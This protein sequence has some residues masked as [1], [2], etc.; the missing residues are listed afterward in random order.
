[1]RFSSKHLN[2]TIS[3]A[4]SEMACF[5]EGDNQLEFGKK[6]NKTKQNTK[7]KTKNQSV[8]TVTVSLSLSGVG[9]CLE[10]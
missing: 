7:N 5:K 1:M 4:G 2:L 3:L 9:R 10:M 8:L 6:Q